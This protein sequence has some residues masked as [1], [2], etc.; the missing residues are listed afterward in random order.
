MVLHS[1]VKGTNDA[2]YLALRGSY[3]VQSSVVITQSSW[4]Y[5]IQHCDDSGRT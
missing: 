4:S 5:Y 2:S 1:D 3:G